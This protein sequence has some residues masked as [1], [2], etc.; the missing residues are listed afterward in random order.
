MIEAKDNSSKAIL[1]VDDDESILSFLVFCL[2]SEGFQVLSAKS[3]EDALS[4]L[5]NKTPDL[6]LLDIMLPMM[7]G[8]ALCKLLRREPKTAKV[9]VLFITAYADPANLQKS[10][11]CGRARPH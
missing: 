9:P 1:V 6:V 10:S 4:V 5:K 8:F 3:A 2:K 7:D 11:G